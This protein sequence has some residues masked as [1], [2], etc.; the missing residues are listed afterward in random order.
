MTQDPRREIRVT[1]RE[2]DILELM[3]E[4]PKLS[5]TEITDAV[6]RHGPMRVDVET[7][8]RRLSALKT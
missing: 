6:T 1:V 4:F 5:R 2:P 3:H 7:E 8:L